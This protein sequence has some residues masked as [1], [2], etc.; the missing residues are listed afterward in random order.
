[1]FIHTTMAEKVLQVYRMKQ[2]ETIMS[3]I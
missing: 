1:M 3:V 2:T